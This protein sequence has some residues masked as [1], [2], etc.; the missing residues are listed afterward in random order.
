[1][2]EGRSFEERDRFSRRTLR[3]ILVN[4]VGTF[5]TDL[6][7]RDGK[8]IGYAVYHSRRNSQRLRLYSVCVVEGERGKGCAKEY[9][10]GRLPDFEGF[11][12]IVLEVR[13][14]NRTAMQ[15]Y[16]GL[17]FK[18]ERRLAGYYSGDE[19]GLRM[20]RRAPSGRTPLR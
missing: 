2:M 19:I 11:K 6:I 18:V 7:L 20:V 15:L 5:I 1:M 16:E 17:G 14:S 13:E 3:R 12:E 8:P 4:P 9:L 10:E